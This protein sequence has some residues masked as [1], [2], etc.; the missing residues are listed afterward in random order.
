MLMEKYIHRIE[1]GFLFPIEEQCSVASIPKSVTLFQEPV[2]SGQNSIKAEKIDHRRKPAIYEPR[3]ELTMQEMRNFLME[4]REIE[5]VKGIKYVKLHVTARMIIGI[6]EASG[7]EFTINLDDLFRAYQNCLRFT[8][9][10]VKKYIFI[11]VR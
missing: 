10:E 4:L 1:E 8:S 9:P 5:S 7:K 2:T 3:P 6:R 11:A